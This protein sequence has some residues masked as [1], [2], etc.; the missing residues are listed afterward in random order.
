MN[1]LKM[2][3]LVLLACGAYWLLDQVIS[4]GW[5]NR[6]Q[7][8]SHAVTATVIHTVEQ[9]ESV[10]L[11]ASGPSPSDS[12]CD[13]RRYCSQMTS[14]AEAQYFLSHCPNTEMDGDHD[15]IPCE[16]QWCGRR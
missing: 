11:P 12:R 1:I 6:F 4:S 8:S 9:L 2:F 14:C 5:L 3:G 16:K 13:G 15:G 10:P 7:H